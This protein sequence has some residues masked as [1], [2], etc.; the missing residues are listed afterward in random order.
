MIISQYFL[1]SISTSLNAVV[2]KT[3]NQ[4]KWQKQHSRAN[5]YRKSSLLIRFM[6][7]KIEGLFNA[8][9]SYYDSRLIIFPDSCSNK[10]PNTKKKK[11]IHLNIQL[12]LMSSLNFLV[13]SSNPCN[14]H[15]S[16]FSIK[17]INQRK[18][19]SSKNSIA[20]NENSILF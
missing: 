8:F 12:Y 7:P 16:N 2:L 4:S 13:H 1:I 20:N 15:H 11:S 5:T 9:S 18:T 19:K 14:L 17:K 6:N 10:H 3:C